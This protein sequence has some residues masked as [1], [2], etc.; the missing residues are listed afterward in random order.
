MSAHQSPAG[1]KA[2]GRGRETFPLEA[3]RLE[4]AQWPAPDRVAWEAA[5]SPAESPF[6]MPGQAAHL[7]EATRR[8]RSGTWGAFLAFL[9]SVDDLNPTDGSA[10]RLTE[11]RLRAWILRLRVR[12]APTTLAQLLRD[13]SLA[14]TAMFPNSDWG[15]VRRHPLRPTPA[16]LRTGRRPVVPFDPAALVE[17]ALAECDAADGPAPSP[18]QARRHRD[19]LLLALAALT[20]L[21]RGNLAEIT[22]GQHL[23]EVGDGWRLSFE[24]ADTKTGAVLEL[25]IPTVLLDPLRAHLDRHRPVLLA[26]RP[27]HGRLWVNIGGEPL[28]YGALW[29]LFERKGRA[30]LG[31]KINPHLTRH[32]LATTLLTEDPSDIATAA[33]A[34]A[35][36]G[37]RSVSEVYDRSGREGA[38][39]E[40]ARV[41]RSLRRPPAP[42]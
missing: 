31:R 18:A 21:R 32:T 26:G 29:G 42:R 19:G 25:R 2:R 1:A 37:T 22:I 4:P 33:A 34:L 39:R 16:E 17:T 35:H 38:D 7:A 20:A 13:L 3:R 6:D 5:I 9:E 10:E 41:L 27:D 40:W 24:A 36:R 14:A 30:L 12:V 15:W 28:A 8:A 11:P 23:R